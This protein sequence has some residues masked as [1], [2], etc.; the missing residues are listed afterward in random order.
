MK[1]SCPYWTGNYNIKGK[2][3]K[4]KETRVIK[5]GDNKNLRINTYI[6][7]EIIKY[8]Q[9]AKELAKQLEDK[10]RKPMQGVVPNTQQHIEVV[11]KI[12]DSKKTVFGGN[13]L[14]REIM[15]NKELEDYRRKWF[16][17]KGKFTA[18]FAT[19]LRM[20]EHVVPNIGQ[21]QGYFIKH[22]AHNAWEIESA[23]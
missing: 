9:K 7:N 11:K 13:E 3:M 8:N 18:H 21:E 15:L 17:E 4:L 19:V 20:L 14:A 22:L 5:V 10:N 1:S 23:A 2:I 6:D 16:G 12:L